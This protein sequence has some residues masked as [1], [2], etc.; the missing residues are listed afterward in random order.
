MIMR[1]IESR[2]YERRLEALGLVSLVTQRHKK[3][4]VAINKFSKGYRLCKVK[5]NIGTGTND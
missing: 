4:K 3:D 1:E 5:N 2:L